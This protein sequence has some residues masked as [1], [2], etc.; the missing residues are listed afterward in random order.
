MQTFVLHLKNNNRGASPLGGC[1][2]PYLV[3]IAIYG[4]AFIVLLMDMIVW[5]PN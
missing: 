3:E 4:A 5:N 1:M 2:K